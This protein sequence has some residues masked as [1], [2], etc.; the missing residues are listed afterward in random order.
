MALPFS[1]AAGRRNARGAETEAE[2]I[3]DRGTAELEAARNWAGG[4]ANELARTCPG[5]LSASSFGTVTERIE[6]KRVRGSV[7]PREALLSAG[8]GGEGLR[9]IEGTFAWRAAER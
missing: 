1:L 9:L 6:A 8:F 4:P 5:F 3:P 2:A 7:F